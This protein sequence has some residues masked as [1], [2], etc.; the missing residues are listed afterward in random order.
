MIL[1]F[2]KGHI[3]WNKGKTGIYSKEHQKK[4]SELMKELYASGFIHPMTGKKH[5]KSAKQKNRLAHL[6][7]KASPETKAKMSKSNKK[8]YAGGYQS[9]NKGRKH[10]KEA[11]EKIRLASLGRPVSDETRKKRSL[12]RIGKKFSEEVKRNM[13]KAAKKKFSGPKGDEIRRNMSKAAKKLFANGYV[14][15]RLGYKATEEEVKKMSET[16]KKLYASGKYNPRLG[17]K[18]SPEL[19]KKLSEV[20]STPELIAFQREKRQHQIFP[21]KDSKI[22]KILQKGLRKKGIKFEKHKPILGQPDVFIEP[23]VCIFADGDFWHG[24]DYLHGKD[25]SQRKEFNNEYFD[26][27]ILY[28]KEITQNLKKNGYK[29]LRFWE[30]EI[31]K[32]PEE[33]LQKIIKTIK[34]S[35]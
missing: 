7:K 8:L 25:F 29:V 31:M 15:P 13:S 32:N 30:H 21:V 19:R 4:H 14:H 16:T 26:K 34:E 10:T 27:K 33:C 18:A 9:P 23:N 5:T 35:N 12:A 28:D 3:P 1:T 6:G 22:E 11:I 17:V 24:W 20:H 2:K